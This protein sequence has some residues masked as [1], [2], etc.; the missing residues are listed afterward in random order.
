MSHRRGEPT[1]WQRK[2]HEHNEGLE[3]MAWPI[4][5]LCFSD[6]SEDKLRDSGSLINVKEK[7]CSHHNDPGF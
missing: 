6:S 5:V 7:L 3:N 1:N 4:E 2:V